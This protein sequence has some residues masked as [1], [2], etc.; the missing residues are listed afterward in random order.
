LD[1]Y[2]YVHFYLHDYNRW[3]KRLWH[4]IKYIFGHKSRYGHW[5]EIL[6][7][8]DE[9]EPLIEYLQDALKTVKQ[10]TDDRMKGVGK[11]PCD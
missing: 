7:E 10:N 4:G 5:D 1:E 9:I 2:L 3:W 8:A 6:I 11:K